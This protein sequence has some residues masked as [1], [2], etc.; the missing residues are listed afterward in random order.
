MKG[1]NNIMRDSVYKTARLAIYEKQDAG[2]ITESQRD[3]LFAMLEA[4]KEA[5]ELTD[6]KIKEFFDEL[7]DKYPDCSDDIEKLAKKLA[8]CGDDEEEKDD[9]DDSDEEVSESVR[10]LMKM[11]ESL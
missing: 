5:S 10:E 7:S 3:Q 2:E 11:I 9:D 8:K 6:D 4:Q 1:M